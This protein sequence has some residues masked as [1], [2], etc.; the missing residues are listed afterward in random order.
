LHNF[1]IFLHFSIIVLAL[2]IKEK[3]K[4]LNSAGPNPAQA[5]QLRQ[6][7]ARARARAGGFAERTSGFWL[8]VNEFSY[9]LYQSLTNCT[10]V[11][12]VLFLHR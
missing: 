8:N 2:E 5:A 11:P 3:E 10:G 9:Y 6:K 1:S 12:E 4:Q 7:G